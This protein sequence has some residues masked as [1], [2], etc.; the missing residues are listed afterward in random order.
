MSTLKP[1]SGDALQMRRQAF[2]QLAEVPAEVE[3]A[4]DKLAYTSLVSVIVAIDEPP[5]DDR[6]WIYFPHPEA[7]PFNRITHLSN[8]SPRNA[9][10]GKSSIMAEVT[11]RGA[12]PDLDQLQKDVVRS[13]HDDGLLD[14]DRVLFTRA[15]DNH[16]A[17]ILYTHDLE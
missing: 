3:S 15:Y 14:Q 1:A 4:F 7:G 13:L 12:T 5:R 10:E 17:Y 8:Y 11:Y 9:P 2:A 6:S 16:Y